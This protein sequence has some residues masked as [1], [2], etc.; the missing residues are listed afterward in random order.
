M[1]RLTF[2]RLLGLSVLVL[3]ASFLTALSQE[4][5]QSGLQIL[6]QQAQAQAEEFALKLKSAGVTHIG[7]S[8]QGSSNEEFTYN[9]FL[10]ILEKNGFAVSASNNNVEAILEV[11]VL[12]QGASFDEPISGRWK[13]IVRTATEARLRRPSTELVEYMGSFDVSK[14]DVVTQKEEGWWI[15]SNGALS[16]GSSPGAL[17]KILIPIAVIAATAVVVYLFFTVRN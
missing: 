6:R 15:E 2:T 5:E 16:V 8:I 17:E 13:R 9:V 3:H 7:L 4:V 1:F 14:V 12:T 10:E 11:L